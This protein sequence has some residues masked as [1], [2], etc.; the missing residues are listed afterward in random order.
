M[1]DTAI[2]IASRVLHWVPPRVAAEATRLPGIAPPMRM[3][4]ADMRTYLAA[5]REAERL[6]TVAGGMRELGMR[7]LTEWYLWPRRIAARPSPYTHPLLRPHRFFPGLRPQMFYDP[8]DFDWVSR[9]ERNFAVIRQ[10]LRDVLETRDGFLPWRGIQTGEWY[11][12]DGERGSA[13][14]EVPDWNMYYFHKFGERFEENC[15]RCPQTAALLESIPRFTSTSLACFSVLN[16]GMHLAPHFGP[17]NGVL[18]V[19]LPLLGVDGCRIRVGDQERTWQ[20]GKAMIFSDAYEHEVWHDGPATRFVLFFDV[21]HP[22]WAEAEVES[23]DRLVYPRDTDFTRAAA[24]MR[25]Q[26]AR[27]LVGI[28]WWR[29]SDDRT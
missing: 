23:L 9:L 18:R 24:N 20:E 13:V 28:K 19:H 16:P 26:D 10:E 22:D 15:R 29:G 6:P 8:A 12:A 14:G 27:T 3:S 7:S 2:N 5:D 21:W 4:R 1:R 11:R 17:S 25:A